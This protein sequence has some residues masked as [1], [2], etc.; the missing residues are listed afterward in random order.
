MLFASDK[1]RTR[2]YAARATESNSIQLRI[3]MDS[4]EIVLVVMLCVRVAV[5]HRNNS[6]FSQGMCDG[7][8][9]NGGIAQLA[10]QLLALV[11]NSSDE[12]NTS[13]P[14]RPTPACVVGS[15][16][17]ILICA[18]ERWTMDRKSMDDSP[19]GTIIGRVGICSYTH[20]GGETGRQGAEGSQTVPE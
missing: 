12:N 3:K 1:Q 11:R 14:D 6:M 7:V 13:I 9:K 16:E 17:T 19:D 20:K 10:H 8:F 4:V 15:H 2:R 5:R 18:Y